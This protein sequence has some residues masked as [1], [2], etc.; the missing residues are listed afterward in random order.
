MRPLLLAF[1]PVMLAA[2]GT[3]PPKPPDCEGPL[4]PINTPARESALAAPFPS[5]VAPEPMP[6]GS[7]TRH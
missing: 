2:C 7:R 5:P 3:R 4:V 1:V 6:H